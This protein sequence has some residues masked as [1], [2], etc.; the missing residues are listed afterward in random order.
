M[1][2][3]SNNTGTDAERLTAACILS[4]AGGF[5]DIYTY[6]YRGGVFANAVT[7]NMVLFGF[8]LANLEWAMSA[9]YLLAIM[10]YAAGVFTAEFVRRRAQG[11]RLVS[12]HQHIILLEIL[13]LTAV[14]FI[15]YGKPDLAVNAMISFVCALQVQTFRRVHGLP[16]A[17]T[18]CTGNLRSG[19]EALFHNLFARDR[20]ELRKA[21]HY[22]LVIGCFVTGAVGGAVLLRNFG[23]FAFLLAPAGLC[24]VFFLI[25]PRRGRA[26]WRRSLR[27]IARRVT[28]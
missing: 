26:A 20:G 23:R 4:I 21:M 6:L 5:L 2:S 13:C 7:G 17:S 3:A 9:R 1:L 8:H 25:I 19:T 14:V 11:S 22:Y 15:P 28:P 27:K 18:M 12:W 10:F 24:A 16:F